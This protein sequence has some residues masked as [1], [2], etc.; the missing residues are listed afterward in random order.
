MGFSL[1]LGSAG[2]DLLWRLREDSSG[3]TAG[4][5]IRDG[6]LS[7]CRSSVCMLV[8]IH[9]LSLPANV[10]KKGNFSKKLSW[11][12]RDLSAN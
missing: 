7:P 8:A 12:S 9:M 2:A 10:L 3:A 6:N 1:A 4:L 11:S 5:F